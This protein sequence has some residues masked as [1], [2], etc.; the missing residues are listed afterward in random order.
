[1]LQVESDCLFIAFLRTVTL[2]VP[3][4]LPPRDL[5]HLRSSAYA[6]PPGRKT[7]EFV[8]FSCFFASKAAPAFCGG[9]SAI[10]EKKAFDESAVGSRVWALRPFIKRSI[11]K[12]LC[13]GAPASQ[14]RIDKL[15]SMFPQ[16]FQEP[17]PRILSHTCRLYFG[18][19]I[20]SGRPPPQK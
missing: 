7:F 18:P 17:R 12:N 13:F 19:D 9:F 3:T 8:R 10:F 2:P 16:G 15:F 11:Q 14:G 6:T 1:M 5:D 4:P 20:G